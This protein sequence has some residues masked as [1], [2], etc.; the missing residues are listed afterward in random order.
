MEEEQIKE[1]RK[2]NHPGQCWTPKAFCFSNCLHTALI[3]TTES[4]HRDRQRRGGV[5][6]VAV[7]ALIIHP[8]RTLLKYHNASVF[9]SVMR[10]PLLHE[11]RTSRLSLTKETEEAAP[12]ENGPSQRKKSGETRQNQDI[13]HELQQ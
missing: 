2:I 8:I 11:Q 9:I 7:I 4:A 12:A 5:V 10:A 1:G 6:V 13:T 3:I